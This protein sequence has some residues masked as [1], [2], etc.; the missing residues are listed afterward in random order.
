M[1]DQG[2][3]IDAERRVAETLIEATTK[4]ISVEY[5]KAMAYTNLIILA[6]YGAYFGL[7]QV[8]KGNITKRQAMWSA[9]LMLASLVVF[10]IFQLWSLYFRSRSLLERVRIMHDPENR[11]SGTRLLAAFAENDSVER[12]R[13]VRSGR[14]WH[15]V[16]MFT[17]ISGL[18]GEGVLAWAFV[19]SLFC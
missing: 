15:W 16:F 11:A 18:A 5:E 13:S 6:G 19:V 1:A 3:N 17:A 8:T 2:L 10:V 7:W 14:V 9:L 4:F 12:R